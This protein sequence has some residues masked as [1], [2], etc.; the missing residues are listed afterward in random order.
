MKINCYKCGTKIDCKP[1]GECW[2]KDF[3]YKIKTSRI[4]KKNQ[5]CLCKTC[6]SK[7]I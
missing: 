3:P 5:K 2:C 7:E 1:E 6:L 4:N